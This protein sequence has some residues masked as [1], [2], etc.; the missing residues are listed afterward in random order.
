MEGKDIIILG[1]ESS[2]DDTSAAV[3]RNGVLL[4]SVIA[5]QAVH[6]AYGGVVPELAS[7]AHQ[8]NIVPVVHEALKRAGVTKEQ[9][10]AVAFT[11][12]P[13]LMGSL[14]VGVSFA[15]GFA[16]AL[17]IPMIDVNHLQGHVL[18]HFIKESDE[19]TDQPKFPFICLLVSG[20]N[21]QIIRVNAYNDM[22][23]LGQTIDDAA[24]EAIDKCSKVMGLGYPG[25]PIIDKLA[26]QGNPNAYT[27][28]KPHIPG[29]DYSFS[30]LKTSFLY[31]LRDWLKD[32]ADFIEHHK[33]DLAASLEK[34]IVDI[35]MDKLRKAVKDTGINEVA[36]A[37][38]VSAN[39][40]L[41]NAFREH[42][43]KY[44][45]KIY[46]PKFGYTT[47]NAAM[48]AITGYYKYQDKDFCSIDKPAYSRVTI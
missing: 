42:A 3:I 32:D 8:Q 16:R 20:G 17:G 12:G 2:C 29:Y 19:D 40:G 41:R 14:L 39:N 48:I 33:T 26:R 15:K 6:E 30:G 11:R 27:F 23:V 5:S 44:G 38:G 43:A 21:S 9:L 10:S 7:R 45:W 35:L 46:I 28:S 31:S 37:G 36:V 25:G 24:G 13:G 22:Q 34:T 1:I 4:S 47:D 18:A